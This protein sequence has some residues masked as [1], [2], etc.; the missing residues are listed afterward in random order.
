MGVRWYGK[1]AYDRGVVTTETVKAKTLYRVREGDFTFNR[2]DT[3]K[4][5]F[6]VVSPELDGAGTVKLTAD[7]MIKGETLDVRD[8][9][10]VA[11]HERSACRAGPLYDG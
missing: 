7:L 3:Q 6:D 9:R 2:I 4:G 5:A 1:G 10:G 11:V 8:C